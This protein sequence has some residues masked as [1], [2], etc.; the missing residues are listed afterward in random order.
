MSWA[1]IVLFTYNRPEHTRR[2]IDALKENIGAHDS[3]LYIFSDG[4]KDERQISVVQSVRSYL[5]CVDGFKSVK[6]V[7][8]TFNMGLAASIIRGVGEVL[9]QYSS[10]VVLEDD[11]VSAPS[12]LPFMNSA[13]TAYQSR[14]DIFSI[15]GYNYPLPIPADYPEPAYLSYRGSSWGWGTWS[16]RW[17][18][19][20]WQVRDFEELLRSKP[21]KARFARGGHD[22][23]PMLIKQMNGEIDS[24]AIRFDYAHAKNGALCLHPVRSLIQNIGFDGT[25]VHCGMTD[26]FDV[27]LEQ[28]MRHLNL[29]PNIAVDPDILR[30]FNERFCPV[31]SVKWADI[32]SRSLLRRLVRKIR[33]RTGFGEK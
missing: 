12:F 10:V 26:E 28:G 27:E 20:D 18:L 22:L 16:D 31:P 8:R 15:T 30:I 5:R 7:E 4:P 19:V 25:G 23:L 33:V 13:L 1:P 29:N 17:K 21:A 6:V 32:Q 24:W 3:V 9:D 2:T 14:R 11:L